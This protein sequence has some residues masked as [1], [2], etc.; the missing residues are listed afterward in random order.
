MHIYI[1]IYIYI[2]LFTYIQ[3]SSKLRRLKL[4]ILLVSP[5]MNIRY[6]KGVELR[7]G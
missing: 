2:C 1:Y 5:K 4:N 3:K 7:Q 6:T